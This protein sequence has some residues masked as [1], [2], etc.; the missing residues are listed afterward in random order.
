MTG[1]ITTW[2]AHTN[3]PKPVPLPNLGRCADCGDEIRLR[4]NGRLYAHDCT[5]DGQLPQVALRPTFAR[6]LWMQSKRRDDYTNLATLVA[7]RH[8]RG[9][10]RS[11]KIAAA[12]VEWTTAEELH[13]CMHARQF[14]LTGSEAMRFNGERCGGACRDLAKIAAIYDR[15]IV[16]GNPAL[17]GRDEAAPDATVRRDARG[18]LLP[19]YSD[20]ADCSSSHQRQQDGR[21]ACTATAVWKVVEDH[22]MHLSIGFY[23]DADLPEQHRRAAA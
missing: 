22:G 23:C 7:G 4:G 12:D 13:Q 1:T 21:P 17:V 15:L 8:F 20:F 2:P 6:W 10:T 11:P 5:G 19:D 9:C 16:D 14:D 18:W 3:E